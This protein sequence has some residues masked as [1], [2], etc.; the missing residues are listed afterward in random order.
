MKPTS[1][2]SC[3][4]FMASTLSFAGS[5]TGFLVNSN[6]YDALER[7]KSPKDTLGYVDRDRIGEIRY[8]RPNGKTK[9]FAVVMEDGLRF[10]LDSR[11]NAKAAELMIKLSKQ[12][13]IKVS[14]TGEMR[15]DTMKVD[16][17]SL[18]H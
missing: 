1:H 18:V 14:I 7:N 13:A 17:I 5:W 10:K 9:L 6:C 15:D 11:G 2:L 16:S 12:S 4:L 8:C 3:L